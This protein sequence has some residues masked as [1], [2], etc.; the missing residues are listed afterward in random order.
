MR[1]LILTQ[2]FMPEITA[3]RYLREHQIEP[4]EEVLRSVAGGRPGG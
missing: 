3:A 4:L 1:V 2:H